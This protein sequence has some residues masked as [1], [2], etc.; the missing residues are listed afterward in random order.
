VFELNVAAYPRSANAHDS[1]GEAYLRAGRRAE[2]IR[3]Y[4]RSVAL[5][6]GNRNAVAKLRELEDR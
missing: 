3:S 5:D 1:L 6:P 4:R 2:A